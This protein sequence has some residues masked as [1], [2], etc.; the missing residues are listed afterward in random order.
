MHFT[1]SPSHALRCQRWSYVRGGLNKRERWPSGCAET[2]WHRQE[3]H[4]R[5]LVGVGGREGVFVAKVLVLCVCSGC[6]GQDATQYPLAVVVE[7]YRQGRRWAHRL[8]MRVQV[9]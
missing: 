3:M 4:V 6:E 2:D 5:S 1:L 8:G 7:V 9:A